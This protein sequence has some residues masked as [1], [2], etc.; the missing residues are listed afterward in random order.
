MQHLGE[1]FCHFLEQLWYNDGGVEICVQHLYSS[2]LMLFRPLLDFLHSNW[3]HAF[4]GKPPRN[5]QRTASILLVSPVVVECVQNSCCIRTYVYRS[6]QQNL[7][8]IGNTL[9]IGF[10]SVPGCCSHNP[11]KKII[12]SGLLWGSTGKS[13]CSIWWRLETCMVGHGLLC[14]YF[15]NI[16]WAS[17]FG[18][19]GNRIDC[20]LELLK[21][22][23]LQ[24]HQII[25]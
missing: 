24:L 4:W 7:R 25:P 10:L 11:E 12:D 15:L 8:I 1:I 9:T 21:Y 6:N 22:L 17:F 3:F 18:K 16:L 13:C 2:A 23:V 19:K 20:S 5:L 14:I